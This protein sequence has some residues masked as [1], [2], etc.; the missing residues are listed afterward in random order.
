[1][2]VQTYSIRMGALWRSCALSASV[3][4][5]KEMQITVK[6][7]TVIAMSGRFFM[8]FF[9]L[10]RALYVSAENMTEGGDGVCTIS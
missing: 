8:T 10:N 6:I 9:A 3:I 5:V 4:Q 2:S 7:R 1:M